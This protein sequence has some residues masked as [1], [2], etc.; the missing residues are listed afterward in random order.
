MSSN[1]RRFKVDLNAGNSR[2]SLG[3]EGSGLSL[4]NDHHATDL[5]AHNAKAQIAFLS[6]CKESV[7]LNNLYFSNF[8]A[9]RLNVLGGFIDSGIQGLCENPECVNREIKNIK[10]SYSNGE[11]IQAIVE[12]ILGKDVLSE[13]QDGIF[14]TDITFGNDLYQRGKFRAF[15]LYAVN[16]PGEES[17]SQWLVVFLLDPYHLVCPVAVGK[18]DADQVMKEEFLRVKDYTTS[19][20]EIFFEKFKN[21]A[22]INLASLI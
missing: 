22:F 19:I 1:S 21:L 16:D 13:Y 12:R 10:L 6:K 2:T 5:N 17:E 4:M 3:I 15:L 7:K 11:R 14:E 9:D 8:L 18:K 20:N